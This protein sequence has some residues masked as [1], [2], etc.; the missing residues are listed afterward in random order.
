MFICQTFKFFQDLK[1]RWILFLLTKCK[2]VSSIIGFD[3]KNTASD[4]AYTGVTE[5][6][7]IFRFFGIFL[8]ILPLSSS[9]SSFSQIEP[10]RF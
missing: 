8:E 9:I 10:W 3:E 2:N 5:M 6:K 4:A 7:H 1:L